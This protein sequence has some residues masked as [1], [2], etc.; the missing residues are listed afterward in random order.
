MRYLLAGKES[1]ERVT[2]LLTFTKISSANL[3]QALLDHLVDGKDP[4]PAAI[5]NDVD[6]SNF[7]RGLAKLEKV[8]KAVERIKELDLHHLVT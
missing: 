2:L 7:E 6:R 3:K 1:H 8:T 5:L 4:N